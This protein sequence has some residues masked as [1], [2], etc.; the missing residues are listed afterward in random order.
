ME[1]QKETAQKLVESWRPGC[2]VDQVEEIAPDAST[3]LY[4]RLL[5]SDP[6]PNSPASVVVMKI[7][8][9]GSQE[10]TG[11]VES[12]SSDAAY[13]QLTKFFKTRSVNVPAIYLDKR[14]QGFLLI[15]D[16]GSD[17]LGDLIDVKRSHFNEEEKDSVF[18]DAV[19][20]II[21]IQ[22]CRDSQNFFAFKRRFTLDLFQKECSEFIQFYLT[23]LPE[24]PVDA[25][26][27]INQMICSLCSELS[28]YPKVLAHRDFHPWNLQL[29]AQKRVRVI[30]FQDALLAPA[31][32]DLASLLNDRGADQLLGERRYR[33]LFQYFFSCSGDGGEGLREYDRCLL[34]RDL[35]VVGRFE[36]LATT[37]GLER[38]RKWIAPTLYRIGQTM[39]RIVR[40]EASE[41]Y[42]RALDSL[43]SVIPRVA[44]GREKP[45][46]FREA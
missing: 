15:E 19:D 10:I 9:S 46:L 11:K 14:E 29:D 30:D 1:L 2:I 41:P 45:L 44:E 24:V 8:D 18:K 39:E 22:S 6:D 4:F 38:Y 37:R 32:Y 21:A 43:S 17:S 40:E 26:E 34:Q 33:F 13:V 12:V 35:K 36:K 3:R 20:Q 7:A 27:Q 23:S 25:L 42:A 16:L 5:L 28:A 31:S